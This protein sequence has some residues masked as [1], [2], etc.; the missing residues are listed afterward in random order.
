M[1]TRRISAGACT[2]SESTIYVFGGRSEGDKFFDS[3]EKYNIEM[4][5]WTML[6]VKLP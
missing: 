2:L 1:I 3:I 5:L 4:D 6:E